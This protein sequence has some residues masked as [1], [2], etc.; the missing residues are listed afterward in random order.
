[1]QLGCSLVPI[2]SVHLALNS[3]LEAIVLWQHV[4][5][6][7]GSQTSLQTVCECVDVCVHLCVCV[8]VKTEKKRAG[9]EEVRVESLLSWLCKWIWQ[10]HF[11][12]VCTQCTCMYRIIHVACSVNDKGAHCLRL[13][14]LYSKTNFQRRTLRS[15]RKWVIM[16]TT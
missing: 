6:K 12:G 10:E 3:T 13:S 9:P 2:T 1:M 16:S 8:S 14:T 4:H 7:C 11:Q 5:L 15:T